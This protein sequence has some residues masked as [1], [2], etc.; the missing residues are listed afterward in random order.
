MRS[1]EFCRHVESEVI[2]VLKLFVTELQPVWGAWPD[3]FL[4]QDRLKDTVNSLAHIF[5]Q[6]GNSELNG[7]F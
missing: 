6:Q 2:A 1:G 5:E 4:L 3:K 7:I